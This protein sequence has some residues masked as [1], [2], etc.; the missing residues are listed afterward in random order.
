M[1]KLPCVLVVA[2]SSATAAQNASIGD[3]DDPDD[4]TPASYVTALVESAIVLGVSATWYWTHEKENKVDFDLHWDWPSWEKKLNFSAVKLDTNEFSVNA[5]HHPL[6]SVIQ[7][8]IART[9][10]FG[11]LGSWLWSTGYGVFWEYFIEYREYP[12]LNDMIIN[13]STGV[14]IG[15]PLWEIGQLWRGGDVSVSDRIQTAMFS[16]FDAGQD[17]WGG[18]FRRFRPRAWRSI[19]LS[20]GVLQRYDDSK[21]HNRLAFISDIDLVADR[22]YITPSAYSGSIR[23]GSWSRLRSRLEL[24]QGVGDGL[25]RAELDSRTAIVGHYRQDDEGRG[26]FLAIGSAFNYRREVASDLEDRVAVADL[27]GPQVQLSLR[28]PNVAVRWDLAGYTNF[29]L[30]EAFVFQPNPPFVPPP[31]YISALQAQGYYYGFGFSETTRLRIDSRHWSFDT[32]LTSHQEWQLDGPDRVDVPDSSATV[33][34]HSTVL[35]NAHGVSDT[36]TYARAQLGFRV[37]RYGLS[38]FAGGEHRTSEWRA[39]RRELTATELGL[40]GHLDF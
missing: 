31:P 23:P 21:T 22:H 10:H 7:Y 24:E 37:G 14:E 36:R 19:A 38:A 2:I 40:L 25:A 11:V 13:A 1:R 39:M 30:I 20:G 28:T 32:E 29:A 17:Y 6:Q 15:E 4:H 18:R 34:A 5:V 26:V 16:P 3:D 8:H 9:N 12:S 33:T 27:L 35:Q